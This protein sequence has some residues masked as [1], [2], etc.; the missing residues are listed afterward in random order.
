MYFK[1][2]TKFH[3][4]R[5]HRNMELNLHLQRLK[6][7]KQLL[8]SYFQDMSNLEPIFTFLLLPFFV[9]VTIKLS[10]YLATMWSAALL[11]LFRI[12]C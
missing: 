8:E 4:G 9:I 10:F 7:T 11:P 6:P 3:T 2:H 5:N 1:G 12:S